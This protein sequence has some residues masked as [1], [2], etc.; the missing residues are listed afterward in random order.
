MKGTRTVEVQAIGRLW[1]PQVPAPF[2]RRY[3]VGKGPFEED[4]NTLRDAEQVFFT[5]CG[6][7]SAI[8]DYEITYVVRRRYTKPC[9]VGTICHTRQKVARKWADEGSEERF[10]F[11]TVD[12]E[13]R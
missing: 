1:W 4:I 12:G 3:N 13:E 7:F 10:V 6:D 9:V 8:E 11:L 2:T 5:D